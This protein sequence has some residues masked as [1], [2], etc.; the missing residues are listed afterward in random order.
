[1]LQDGIPTSLLNLSSENMPRAVKMFGGVQKYMGADGPDSVTE[2]QRVEIAG[3]LLHQA[4]RRPELKDEL[5]MQA[6]VA[7]L[8][9]HW[10]AG[11]AYRSLDPGVTA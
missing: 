10:L 9:A 2:A 3:K 8:C 6:S 4:I 5:Y 7:G 1:M 11:L